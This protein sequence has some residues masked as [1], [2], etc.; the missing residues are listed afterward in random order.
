MEDFF[1]ISTH[2][3]QVLDQ[4]LLQ[5]PFLSKQTTHIFQF[6][7]EP[8]AYFLQMGLSITLFQE[9][10]SLKI[11]MFLISPQMQMISNS[12]IIPENVLPALRTQFYSYA[13][14]SQ[15]WFV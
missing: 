13:A 14:Q 3:L 11:L 10:I 6:T 7:A 5:L 1:Q 2:L 12:V 9:N 4:T 8:T 15:A